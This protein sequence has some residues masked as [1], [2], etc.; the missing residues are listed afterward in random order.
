[1][2]RL[3]GN[4]RSCCRW[5]LETT[6]PARHY[7]IEPVTRDVVLFEHRR[8]RFFHLLGLFC[9]AQTGFWAY[10]AYFGFTTLRDI[11]QTNKEENEEVKGRNMGSPLWRTAFTLGCLSVGTLVMVAGLLFSRRSVSL[12]TLHAGGDK[13]TL[14]TAGVF[15]IS[16]SFSL[17]LRHISSMAH[18][19]EVPAM[20]PLKIKGRPLYYL[21]D[22]Q[23]HVSNAKLFDL[24]VGAYRNL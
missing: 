19:S 24:T 16:S 11:R 15:G 3:L 7:K 12:V 1:M 20:I 17:P 9:V 23:G 21:L 6:F 4:L 2:N 8:P 13:V 14:V 5:R 10:L 18:R 22:K